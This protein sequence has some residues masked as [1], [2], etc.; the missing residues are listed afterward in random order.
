MIK[1]IA[2]DMDGTF[3]NP[4]SEYDHEYFNRLWPRIQAAG[5]TLVVASG[6]PYYQL[7]S[8]FLKTAD[9]MNFVAENGVECFDH[10]QMVYCGEIGQDVQDAIWK[11]HQQI[12]GSDFLLS[13]L[14]SS[15][16]PVTEREGFVKEIRPHY[17]N[18]RRIKHLAEVDDRI[19]KF[20]LDVPKERTLELQQK[21]NHEFGDQLTAVSSGFGNLD[22]IVAG[23][24]K[25]YGLQKLMDRHGWQ[26][27]E[28]MAFGDGQNDASMLR[29]AGVSYAMINGGKEAKAAADHLA[30]SNADN[31]VLKTI[32]Q[33]LDQLEK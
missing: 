21:I 29:L 14:H 24:D 6:N 15:Y 13:G 3:L 11:L 5:I 8:R 4:A 18:I 22:L 2:F 23:M 26:A 1:A 7:R 9:Q 32:E 19:V 33:Y 27:N 17:P 10:G 30:P 12:P 20:L 25:A 31:G 28:V 16:I